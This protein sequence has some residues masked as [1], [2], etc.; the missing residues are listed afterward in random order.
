LGRRKCDSLAGKNVAV[1]DTA[2]SDLLAIHRIN[3]R[4]GIELAVRL[5]QARLLVLLLLLFLAAE[6]R[7]AADANAAHGSRSGADA[8]PGG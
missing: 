1:P 3:E 2:G 5:V 4:C 8:R 7:K 6:A